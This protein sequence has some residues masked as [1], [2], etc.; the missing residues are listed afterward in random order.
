MERESEKKSHQNNRERERGEGDGRQRVWKESKSELLVANDLTRYGSNCF[1]AFIKC[2]LNRLLV[3]RKRA[4]TGLFPPHL[5]AS[6]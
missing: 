2:P 4:D 1:I 6:A 3:W 5:K